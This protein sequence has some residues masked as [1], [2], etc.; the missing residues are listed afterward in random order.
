MS[1]FS[2]E[3]KRK[4][5]G[6]AAQLA[7]PRQTAKGRNA[8]TN[9]VLTIKTKNSKDA[10]LTKEFKNEKDAMTYLLSC[11]EVKDHK[12]HCSKGYVSG[13]DIVVTKCYYANRGDNLGQISFKHGKEMIEW[14][15]FKTEAEYKTIK[16]ERLPVISGQKKPEWEKYRLYFDGDLV[17]TIAELGSHPVAATLPAAV[18]A[19][20][21]RKAAKKKAAKTP[22]KKES[23]KAEY[24]IIEIMGKKFY[25]V[26]VED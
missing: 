20:R 1:G 23:K 10:L 2:E 15:P 24:T 9:C 25:L 7:A 3:K 13:T 6:S 19:K 16:E 5:G 8:M 11:K 14:K 18:D 21:E 17:A 26:P 4:C 22:A 12:L